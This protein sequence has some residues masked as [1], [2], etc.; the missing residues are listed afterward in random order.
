[1]ESSRFGSGRAEAAP[2]GRR[3]GA[4]EGSLS[5]GIVA[6]G[7][8]VSRSRQ[9]MRP[10]PPILGG[11]QMNALAHEQAPLLRRTSPELTPLAGA[12]RATRVM[13]V[14]DSRLVAEALM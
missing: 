12:R 2:A 4:R 7:P 3:A 10:N 8:Q 6:Q 5:R 13:V 14:D 11:T 1:Y 9:P